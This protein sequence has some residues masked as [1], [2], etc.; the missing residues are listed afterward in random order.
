MS[1]SQVE[2]KTEFFYQSWG[3]VTGI[4]VP[5]PDDVRKGTILT[6]TGSYQAHVNIKIKTLAHDK[7][8]KGLLS[9]EEQVFSVWLRTFKNEPY[10]LYKIVSFTTPDK[11]LNSGVAHQQ[12]IV[13]GQLVSC[14]E[15][16]QARELIIKIRPNP[17]HLNSKFELKPFPIR[18]LDSG[19][20]KYTVGN[21]YRFLAQ[22]E[23]M[24]LKVI[25]V[26]GE[27]PSTEPSELGIH[28]KHRSKSS[29]STV[30]SNG[31]TRRKTP[32]PSPK[33]TV[34]L[35]KKAAAEY[36]GV[37]TR[38]IDNYLKAG[39]I[40]NRQS[41]GKFDRS[42][43][44]EWSAERAALKV[45]TPND[46][47]TYLLRGKAHFRTDNWHK[48]IGELDRAIDLAPDLAKAYVKRFFARLQIGEREAAIADLN[49]AASLFQQQGDEDN[50]RKAMQRLSKMKPVSKNMG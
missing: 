14:R 49:M 46:A 13:S 48:A 37:T 27:Y 40:S 41:D 2:S 20:N 19:N 23:Q 10:L 28:D 7:I 44:E 42:L 11:Y 12:F 9:G 50:Y 1:E 32:L 3:L 35:D 21:N 4:Y 22:Q 43:L 34:W 39:K 29:S 5:S 18:L 47:Q 17:N 30:E 16:E 25:R 33:K 38:T 15:G 24:E 26:D 31:R 45:K 36:L 6:D 8:L